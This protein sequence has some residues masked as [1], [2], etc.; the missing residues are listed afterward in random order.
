MYFSN[1]FLLAFSV[2]SSRIRVEETFS[3]FISINGTPMMQMGLRLFFARSPF[4]IDKFLGITGN[5]LYVLV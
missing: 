2:I 4:I 5:L 1:S 3:P